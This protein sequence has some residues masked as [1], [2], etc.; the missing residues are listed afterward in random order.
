MIC[1]QVMID[2]RSTYIRQ[3]DMRTN[4][5]RSDRTDVCFLGSY[6][7]SMMVIKP[8]FKRC[9]AVQILKLSLYESKQC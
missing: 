5:Q 4:H 6:I 1:I 9:K 2:I 7:E 8:N 3:K